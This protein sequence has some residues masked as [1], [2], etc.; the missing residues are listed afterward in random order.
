VA[1]NVTSTAK[2]AEHGVTVN[3]RWP[4]VELMELGSNLNPIPF[5]VI[6]L[7]D[8]IEDI[9]VDKFAI[10]LAFVSV[11]DNSELEFNPVISKIARS[12][13]NFMSILP[14]I[15]TILLNFSY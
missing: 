4:W 5:L 13:I 11:L 3:A 10:L 12:L 9:G 15:L 2:S 1:L 7:N 14:S 6:S 8:F